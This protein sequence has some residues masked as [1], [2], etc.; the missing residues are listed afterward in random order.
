[1]S[2]PRDKG[3]CGV[4]GVQ[5]GDRTAGVA[6]GLLIS[7]AGPLGLSCGLVLTGL[8]FL[9]IVIWT[10]VGPGD[11]PRFREKL[12]V[13]ARSQKHPL[14]LTLATVAGSTGTPLPK[15]P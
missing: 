14:P 2:L 13:A 6:A 3:G 12:P 8:S 15:H 10:S 4:T 5:D 1:M 9:I 11:P 7:R